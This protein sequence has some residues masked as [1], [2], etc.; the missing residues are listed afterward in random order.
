MKSKKE[1]IRQKGKTMKRELK[2]RIK[3]TTVVTKSRSP[4]VGKTIPAAASLLA[5]A[6]TLAL[7]CQSADPKSRSSRT[8][9]GDI[10]VANSSN[11]TLTIG[12]GSLL[13]A[14]GGGDATTASPVQTTDTKPELAVALPGASAGTGGAKPA[15]GLTE[16]VLTALQKLLNGE[17]PPADTLT[18]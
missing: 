9:Y 12:D 13:S 3:G 10:I 2:R 14:D 6:L 4:G 5:L 16:T 18:P 8:S 17:S 7:G 11:V 15:S 1:I